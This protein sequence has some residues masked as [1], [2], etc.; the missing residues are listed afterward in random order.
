MSFPAVSASDLLRERTSNS[1]STGSSELDS[2]FGDGLAPGSVLQI[3]GPPGSGRERLFTAI[4][5]AVLA[6]GSRALIYS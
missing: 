5:K 1:Y 3:V 6:K 2:V 4:V